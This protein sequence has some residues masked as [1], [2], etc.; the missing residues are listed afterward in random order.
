[1]SDGREN[2]MV[3]FRAHEM[4]TG[5]A[6][7]ARA[8]FEQMI[9]QLVDAL[10]PGARQVSAN[11]GDGGIDVFLGRLDRQITV[12][13]SKYF[14][15]QV[16][17]NHRGQIMESFA[18]AQRNARAHGYRIGEW[19]LCVPSSMDHPTTLW[20]DSWRRARQAETSTEIDIWDETALR[21]RLAR[22]AAAAVLAAFYPP[23]GPRP[24]L[25]A[26]A[27]ASAPAPAPGTATAIVVPAAEIAADVSAPPPAAT[28]QQRPHAGETVR[29]AG[30]RCLLHGD[31]EEWRGDAWIL[32]TGAATVLPSPS[33]PSSP[34]SPPKPSNPKPSKRP[35]PHRPA[36][37]RQ[38]L[39]GRPG[40][41]ADAH[42]AAIDTQARLL[43][44]F[45]GRGGLPR[46]VESRVGPAEAAVICAR[47][48]GRTWREVLGPMDAAA[49]GRPL[50]PAEAAALLA[51]AANLAEILTR[52]HETGHDHR[53]LVPD[54]VAL[55]GGY[56]PGVALR[57]IGLAAVPR[58]PGEGPAEYRAPEQERLGFHGPQVG[59]R[60]DAYRLAAM[61][62]H[63]LTGQP[64]AFGEVV[65]LRAFGLQVPD[66][67]DEA[68]RTG[69]DPDPDRRPSLR[70]RFT[71][72]LRAGIDYFARAGR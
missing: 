21:S 53:A 3:N 12:W 19:I 9:A 26:L 49:R 63:C 56:G 39:I 22:P 30:R 68:L 47:P 57:D 62:Y 24:R 31:P 28:A 35:E 14:M 36:W 72:A 66:E 27:P 15:P 59:V 1:M 5:S 33:S 2:R 34:S 41:E 44:R 29:I 42:A 50:N 37:F 20:W 23:T 10:H 32:R 58:R 64:P 51:V 38:V 16:T 69:L 45:G 40:P 52:L 54:G 71:P 25:P 4:N 61:T 7:G 70:D 17:R 13:Q 6:A 43:D 46:L 48:A 8:D 65:P 55:L 60:T 67:L 11:P 18:S